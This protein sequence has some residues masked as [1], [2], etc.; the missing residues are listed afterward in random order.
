MRQAVSGKE[1]QAHS[2]SNDSLSLSLSLSPRRLSYRTGQDTANCDT[3]RN[4]AC[5]IYRLVAVLCFVKLQ[6]CAE[7]R[8][9]VQL[10]PAAAKI[11]DVASSL[12]PFY[13]LLYIVIMTVKPKRKHILQNG[14]HEKKN[15]LFLHNLMPYQ[16]CMS[17]L[18]QSNTIFF[19]LLSFIYFFSIISVTSC[20]L[21]GQNLLK[22][23]KYKK[24]QFFKMTKKCLLKR[25]DMYVTIFCINFLLKQN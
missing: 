5:I 17:I 16:I 7:M 10:R 3:C 24:V 23:H 9:V 4:S 6:R 25:N 14:S 15:A 19:F 18:L 20:P 11:L 1:E 12:P 21:I 8:N 2:S 13:F 22:L